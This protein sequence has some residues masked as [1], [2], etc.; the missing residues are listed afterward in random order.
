LT[1][2]PTQEQIDALIESAATELH[3]EMGF[4]GTSFVLINDQGVQVVP[5]LRTFEIVLLK[6]MEDKNGS[7]NCHAQRGSRA[8]GRE[9]TRG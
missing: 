4:W 6:A 7:K 2:T 5:Y 3:Q 1:I 9:R 8:A